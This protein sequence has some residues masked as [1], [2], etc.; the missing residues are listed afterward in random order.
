MHTEAVAGNQQSLEHSSNLPLCPALEVGHRTRMNG[1]QAVLLLVPE[2]L[3]PVK[4]VYL[5]YVGPQ[6][7][8]AQSMAFTAHSSEQV[9]TRVF[10][11][12]LWL[13][14]EVHKSQPVHFS[15]LLTWLYVDLPYNLGGKGVFLLVSS[16][17]SVKIVLL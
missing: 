14:F 17:S 1:V 6:D 3:W 2:I 8:G 7:W 10:S 5:S 9:S 13:S 12:F 15:S 11:L 16:W 4:G